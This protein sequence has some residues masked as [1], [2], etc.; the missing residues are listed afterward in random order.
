MVLNEPKL[1][2]SFFVKGLFVLPKWDHRMSLVKLKVKD[3]KLLTPRIGLGLVYST[4]GDI[5]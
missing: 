3:S 1:F 2:S 5:E 4:Q